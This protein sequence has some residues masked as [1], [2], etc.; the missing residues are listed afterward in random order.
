MKR[1]ISA[2]LMIIM[3]INFGTVAS[4]NVPV[5]RNIFK[6][7]YVEG[8]F[9][10][11]SGERI[12][13]EEYGG[14]V[15]AIPVT[16]NAIFM[17]DDRPIKLTDFKPGMEV[18]AEFQGRS[19]KH[20]DAFSVDKPGYIQVGGKVRVGT[21]KV[22]DRDQ[23][24]IILPTGQE[25][26]YFTSPRTII[27]RNQ[28]NVNANSLYVGDRVKLYFDDTDTSYI[29]RLEIE[30]E[31]IMI[32]DLYRGSLTV[33]DGLSD[34]IA[35]E[36][37][38]VF[39]NGDWK[40]LGTDLRLPYNSDLPLYVG[41]QKVNYENLKYYRG[42]T[43]YM[44]MKDYFGKEKVEKM[45]VK[46]ENETVFSD[47]IDSINWFSSQL[48]LGNK[49]NINFHDGT[50]VIKNGRLVDSNSLNANSDG[51][52]ITDGR[53][54]DLTADVVYIYN[55]DIN[56]SNVGQDHIYAGR[57]DKIL[58]NKLYLRDFFL[59][60]KNDWVSFS[61][62]KELFYDND[63]FI[64]NVEDGKE[65]SPKEFF[66]SDFSVD[67]YNTKDKKP[68]DWYGY[69]YTDGDRISTVF[70]KKSLD[71]L[72]LQRTST[73]IV[74]TKANLDPRMGWTIKV[75]DAKDWSSNHEEWMM[76][77]SSLDIYLREAMIVKN[78]KKVN[79]D[80]IKIGDRLYFLRDSNMAKVIIVK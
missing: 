2:I 54:N 78:G 36:N 79:I 69:L 31:S 14:R 77:N 40:S 1:K 42:R 10:E 72:Y 29:S 60:D 57:L 76:K 5:N 63:T 28:Q 59:L 75:R 51:L 24:Q 38:D 68:R 16:N 12:F 67:E 71:S 22:I 3:I 19:I 20:M 56:N 52:F 46:A 73:G 11:Y 25:E 43:V 50:M 49:K 64:Y 47:K 7:G 65:V 39:R 41:G 26:T 55:E 58:Q 61:N 32:K 13:I 80:D 62:D 74:E 70:V 23:I 17:I 8:Y 35:L 44:A 66:S 30:G 27:L 37:V 48:E 4:A 6:D 34:V 53:G 18:Y 21:V 15:H 45:V 9:I 33:V